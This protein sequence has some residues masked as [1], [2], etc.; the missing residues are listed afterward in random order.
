MSMVSMGLSFMSKSSGFS[1]MLMFA[2]RRY[3]KASSCT[4]SL[5]LSFTGS[6]FPMCDSTSSILLF[7]ISETNSWFEIDMSLLL[8]LLSSHT[9][10]LMLSTEA[11]DSSESL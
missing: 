1:F 3:C 2:S 7:E 4:L 5:S 9:S 8:L 11:S 6:N 10:T